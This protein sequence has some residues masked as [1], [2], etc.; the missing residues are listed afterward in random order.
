M[1][2]KSKRYEIRVEGKDSR[3]DSV[4]ITESSAAEKYARQFF[5]DDI[6]LYESSFIM[7][8][9]KANKVIGWAKISQGGVS[10]TVVDISIVCKY[11]VETLAKGVILVHNHPSGSPMPGSADIHL[12]DNLR[13]ALRYFDC[14][15]LDHVI[16]T[17]DSAYSFSDEAVIR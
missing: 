9:N 1:E 11:V 17:E 12:T 8:L 3:F 5:S 4:Q 13:K 7:L 14:C 15:L 16:L 6:N 10:S 2:S